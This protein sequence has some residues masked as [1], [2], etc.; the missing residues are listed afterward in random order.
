MIGIER[1]RK[2]K[3][4]Q[5]KVNVCVSVC[6]REREDSI[7]TSKG[8]ENGKFRHCEKRVHKN[9]C[10]SVAKYPLKPTG[11]LFCVIRQHSWV[12]IIVVTQK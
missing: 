11:P 1:K 10:K 3:K 4:Q 6:L 9:S 8:W 5:E 2:E 12:W 7:N